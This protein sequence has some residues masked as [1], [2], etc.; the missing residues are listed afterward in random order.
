[1]TTYLEGG[2]FEPGGGRALECLTKN[3]SSLQLGCRRAIRV[4]EPWVK[5]WRRDCGSDIDKRCKNT[6][7]G[8]HA[9]ACLGKH[10]KRVS[11]SCQSRID[12]AQKG[13]AL[14]CARDIKK[15]C[16]GIKPGGGRILMC[17]ERNR[18][19]LRPLCTAAIP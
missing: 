7:P 11:S 10:R 2:W 17:L 16:K 18:T 4:V 5:K 19:R 13:L 1:M 6:V 15:H 14:V 9:M 3:K 8:W 12:K